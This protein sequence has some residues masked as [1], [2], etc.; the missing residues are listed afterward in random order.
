MQDFYQFLFKCLF[1][2]VAASVVVSAAPRLIDDPLE[3]PNQ[4]S[5]IER[6]QLGPGLRNWQNMELLAQKLALAELQNSNQF[7]L[8]RQDFDAPNGFLPEALRRSTRGGSKSDGGGKRGSRCYFNA[9][10]CWGKK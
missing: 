4:L 3:D 9:V 8:R 10:S 1:V 5:E 2:L 7:Q 6:S